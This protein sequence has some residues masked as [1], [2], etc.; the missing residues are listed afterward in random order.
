M[1]HATAP[2]Y[3]HVWPWLALAPL[4]LVVLASL[5]TLF[6]AGAPP[7]LVV[8][9]GL[10][11]ELAIEQDH[12]RERRATQLGL[13]AEVRFGADAGPASLTVRLRGA[14][15]EALQLRL[16][17]PTRAALDRAA[18]LERAGDAYVGTLAAPATRMYVELSDAAGTWRLRGELARGARVLALS[19]A[20]V[21]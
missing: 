2:W 3:R 20:G 13:A 21:G 16:V 11:L 17:H 5:L 1:A 18:R 14:A 12:A 10:P 9:D 6:I 7:A 15:P 8:G 4:V 19:A